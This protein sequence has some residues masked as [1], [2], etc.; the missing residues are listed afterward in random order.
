M[1]E[2]GPPK[3]YRLRLPDFPFGDTTRI[4]GY[5]IAAGQHA[6]GV[7]FDGGAWGIDFVVTT[8]DNAYTI[9]QAT[10][11]KGEGQPPLGSTA[12]R[13][14]LPIERWVEE[15]LGRIMWPAGGG[16]LDP[17]GAQAELTNRRRRRTVTDELLDQVADV[18]RTAVTEGF[19]APTQAV[20]EQMHVSRSQAAKYVTAARKA[21]KLGPAAP[22]K[23][24]EQ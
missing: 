18:Y 2:L 22:G 1:R 4:G 19:H 17:G 9:D 3:T 12:I 11:T 21:G 13:A 23:R 6:C 16:T 8:A 20:G 7:D 10:F 14:V 24:G 15:C 5:E